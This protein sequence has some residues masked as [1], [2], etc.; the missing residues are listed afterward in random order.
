MVGGNDGASVPATVRGAVAPIRAAHR[1]LMM[2]AASD[3]TT[4][5]VRTLLTQ[6]G[7]GVSEMAKSRSQ[8]TN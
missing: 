7:S 3:R 8:Y 4:I 5:C 1:P 2:M 6:I